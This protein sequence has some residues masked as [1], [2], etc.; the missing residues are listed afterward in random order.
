M[1]QQTCVHN[2]LPPD[3]HD[4]WMSV[5]QWAKQRKKENVEEGGG[6]RRVMRWRR[7][8][9]PN[10]CRLRGGKGIREVGGK[11]RLDGIE[12]DVSPKCGGGRTDRTT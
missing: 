3:D 9:V 11:R 6:I 8:A 10:Y 5:R 4:K 2:E 7:K 12:N 1:G